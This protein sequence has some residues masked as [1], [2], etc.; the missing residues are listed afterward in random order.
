MNRIKNYDDLVA[1]R[2]HLEANLR[3][4]K[5]YLNNKV[6]KI[7]EKFEPINKVISF[8]NGEKNGRGKMLLQTGSSLLKIGST[9]GI[10][11]L[12][13]KKLSKAGWL[14][15][16]VMPFVLRFAAAKTID[17]VEQKTA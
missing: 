9:A 4:Q 17:K 15:K 16:L 13:Q 8:F 2:T 6:G 5:A 12:I 3:E 7:K 11:M 1:H 10:D 14:A